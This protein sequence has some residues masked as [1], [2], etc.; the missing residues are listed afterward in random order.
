MTKIPWCGKESKSSHKVFAATKPGET[1]S[2]DQM[3]STKA[4]FFAKHA[5]KKI[6]AEHGVCIHH[7]HCDN[8]FYANNAFKESCKS[9]RQRLTF[10]GVNAH[11]QNGIAILESEQKQLLHAHAPWTAAV[12]IAPWPYATWNAIFLNFARPATTT[13][14]N[15]DYSLQLTVE[16]FST[17]AYQVAPATTIWNNSF[18]LIDTLASEGAALCSE[19]AQPDPT[20]LCNELC[21]H[22]L[23][24]DFIP[25]TSNLLLSSPVLVDCYFSF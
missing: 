9:S 23:I 11:F 4:G 22:G 7:Y 1:V 25:M 2:V 17:E 10:C 12:H 21:G 19:G 18:K 24:V 15:G 20:I 8:G 13:A 16:S 6:A 5:F 3:V 14:T